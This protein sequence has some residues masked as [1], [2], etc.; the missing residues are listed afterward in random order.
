M[1]ELEHYRRQRQKTKPCSFS[2]LMKIV[3][4]LEDGSRKLTEEYYAALKRS[5]DILQD[6]L[7]D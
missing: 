2:D 1:A 5:G 3:G 7:P 6:A 4:D